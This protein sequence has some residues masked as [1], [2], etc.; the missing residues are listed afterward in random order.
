M[1]WRKHYKIRRLLRERCGVTPEVGVWER[2]TVYSM[3]CTNAN[4][5]SGPYRLRYF[6]VNPYSQ[7]LPPHYHNPMPT[8][9]VPVAVFAVADM[10]WDFE[11]WRERTNSVTLPFHEDAT[12]SQTNLNEGELEAVRALAD[13]IHNITGY[14]PR[15]KAFQEKNDN[16]KAGKAAWS[17]WFKKVHTNWNLRKDIEKLLDTYDKHPRLMVDGVG[18]V[19]T[20]SGRW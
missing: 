16:D 3:W 13:R 12:P 14:A 1:G 19:G 20:V 2:S 9:A 7:A 6:S 15:T 5:H 18:G 8:A 4:P 11:T 10:V 17:K